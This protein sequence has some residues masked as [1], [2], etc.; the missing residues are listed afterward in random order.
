MK[1]LKAIFAGGGT[2]GHLYPALAIADR[3]KALVGFD[4]EADF[5]FVGTKRGIEYRMKERLGYPLS[6]ITVRG[7]SRSGIVRNLLFPFLLAGATIKSIFIILRFSPDVIV[8]TGGYVMG[9][10]LLAAV[11]MNRRCV[12]QE[13][14]SYPGVTTR[15]LAHRVDKV[16]LG[17]GEAVKYF[18]KGCDVVETGNPVKSIIGTVSKEEARKYFG[19]DNDDKI[20][21]V[22]GG[23]QGASSINNNIL[24]HLET[25]SDSYRLIW[26]TGERDYK[27]VAAKAGGR[28][29]G[30]AL[31]AFTDH[32]ELA[33]AAADIAIARAGALTLAELEAAG[34][35]SVLIPYPFAAEDHQR[36]NAEVY[37]A[38][39]ASF[40]IYDKELGEMNL[41]KGTITL[42]EDGSYE[43][44]KAAL[45]TFRL[46]RKK[47]AVD[48]IAEE[49]LALTGFERGNN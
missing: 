11:L 35:P 32:I 15:Q 13:Q 49:I 42:L 9:P 14:N 28:V 22:L 3:L 24:M 12:I 36:K 38:A 23:S 30:R 39:G 29:S 21:L 1:K 45:E 41:L 6:L 8:G 47:P 44:M 2:G 27:E 20:I 48:I 25:L 26:Q 43:K 34:L 16:F 7:L 5:R 40:I 4:C 46:K 17:F 33:Y 18:K 31:F 37:A 10:V 19:F